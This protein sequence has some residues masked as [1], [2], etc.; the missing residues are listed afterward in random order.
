M[1]LPDPTSPC[2]S[3]NILCFDFK[4]L[5]ITS[6]ALF[7]SL[8]NLKFKDFVIF[9]VKSSLKI[10]SFFFIFFIFVL[11][12]EDKRKW[13]NISSNISL[14]KKFEF[15][16]L[17]KF[18]LWI[19]II[20]SFHLTLL[21]FFKTSLLCHSSR[22]GNFVNTSLMILLYFFKLRP[23]VKLYLFWSSKMLLLLFD[24]S[25]GLTSWYLFL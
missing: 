22:L 16:I 20:E 18:S 2:I 17:S 6:M 23:S 15:L 14:F 11:N 10:F 9:F 1:V 12:C 4:S 13:A 3:L 7:W 21:N 5:F 25:V 24:T 19:L 8:V